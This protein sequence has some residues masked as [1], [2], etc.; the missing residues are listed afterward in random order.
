[1]VEHLTESGSSNRSRPEYSH[2]PPNLLGWTS[3]GTE[4]A[5]W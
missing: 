2:L 3:L 5:V 1:V 4:S